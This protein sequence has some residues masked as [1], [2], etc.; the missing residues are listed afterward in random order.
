MKRF[1]VSCI[2]TYETCGYKCLRQYNKIG[3]DKLEDDKN[4]YGEFGALLHD[5]FDKHYKENLTKDKMVDMFYSA[6]NDLECEFPD[7]KKEDYINSA[8]EQIDYFYDKYSIMIPIATEEEFEDFYID[9]ISLPWKGFIDR[10]DGNDKEKSVVISDYKTGRSSKF[11]KRELNDNVQATVYSLYYKQKYGFY[12]E[13]FVF[14][15]TKERKT[16]EIIINEA[17][18]ERGLARIKRSIR[19]MEQGIFLPESKGGKFF[20]KNFCKFYNEC[21]K[22]IKSNDGWDL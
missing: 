12:P 6:L 10:I 22:Y 19:N 18:I 15:F 4:F 20:C 13:R 17:F 5:L 3:E 7:G 1:S 14:I 2:N 11:T 9:G 16:K 8:L 21:P